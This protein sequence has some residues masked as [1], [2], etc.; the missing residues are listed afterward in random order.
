MWGSVPSG[1]PH[2]HPDA[3][4]AAE[5]GQEAQGGRLELPMAMPSPAQGAEQRS[6]PTL[7]L[8]WPLLGYGIKPTPQETP[9]AAQCCPQLP[10]Q[11]Q[12]GCIPSTSATAGQCGWLG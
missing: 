9:Q 4:S 10:S 1:R 3:T 5:K 11:G 7:I 6:H 2:P 8:L 12:G